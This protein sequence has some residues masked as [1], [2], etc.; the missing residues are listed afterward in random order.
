MKVAVRRACL[1]VVF[2]VV[3]VV[4]GVAEPGPFDLTVCIVQMQI[5]PVL[6]ADRAG[7]FGHVDAVVA[8]ACVEG[9]V[10]L[11][12]FPEYVSAFLAVEPYADLIGGNTGFA[13]A[14]ERIA[15]ADPGI[16][17]IPDVF[18]S[19][20]V[21]VR[22]MMDA[23]WGAVARAYDTVVVA[24]TYFAAVPTTGEL[25]NRAIVYGNDGD[26]LYEQD[27]VY[28][29]EFERD[30]LRLTPGSI[31][32]ARPFDVAGCEV[33]MTICRDT[34]F[35]VWE[36]PFAGVDLWIDIKANGTSYTIEEAARFVTA[37]P[38]RV[39]GSGAAYG[40]TACLVGCFLDLYFE[41]RSFVVR[42]DGENAVFTHT[43]VTSNAHEM[44]FATLR[45]PR[46]R[47][48]GTTISDAVLPSGSEPQYGLSA[49]TMR[50]P[51]TT[52]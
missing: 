11:V 2:C 48:L 12:V 40:C 51:S 46:Y 23:G 10:D 22:K 20:S 35:D 36:D 30:V 27:K 18:R 41:G 28:L 50:R 13:A 49:S 25:R 42:R 29:T 3:G 44:L 24:G 32:H 39:I 52:K 8:D 37:A 5:S 31:R 21:R 6:Y 17:S 38:E 45:S 9:D 4:C 14:A 7:F 1:C 19:T 34:F 26:V 43:A 47:R 16:E 33:G 15:R